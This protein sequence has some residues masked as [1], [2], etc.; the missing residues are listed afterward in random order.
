MIDPVALA[1]DAIGRKAQQLLASLPED[2]R[3]FNLKAV[4]RTIMFVSRQRSVVVL[5]TPLVLQ[6]LQSEPIQ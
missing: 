5:E 2:R 1:F 6:L 4:S 3:S